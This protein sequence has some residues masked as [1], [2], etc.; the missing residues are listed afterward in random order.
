MLYAIFFVPETRGRSL[1]EL[2]ELFEHKPSISAWKFK[3]TKTTGIGAKV[4]ALEGS[5]R[6]HLGGD[7]EMVRDDGMKSDEDIY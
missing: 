7:S 5:G 1:E 2:D 4:A 6:S 3:S